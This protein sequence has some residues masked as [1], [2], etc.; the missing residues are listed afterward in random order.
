MSLSRDENHGRCE[1]TL[2]AS[3]F[4]SEEPVQLVL[5][6]VDTGISLVRVEFKSDLD[7]DECILSGFLTALSYIGDMMFPQPFDRMTF[8]QYTMIL[9]VEA[10]FLFC[11]VFSG[12]AVQ[13]SRRLCEFI[14]VLRENTPLLNS[15][16]NTIAFGI[17][18][19][20]A[21]S[22]I[23]EIATRIFGGPR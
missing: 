7:G 17:V 5:S 22:S 15:L 14:K 3:E 4:V 21:K 11:Y 12:S 19:K 2:P 20:A 18:D 10:P 9:R 16:K 23:K 6:A 1:R 8:G 13:A